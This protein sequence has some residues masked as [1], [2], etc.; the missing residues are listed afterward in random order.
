MLIFV[1]FTVKL[2]EIKKHCEL[3]SIVSAGMWELSIKEIQKRMTK[4]VTVVGS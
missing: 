1:F 4:G 2:K 3:D